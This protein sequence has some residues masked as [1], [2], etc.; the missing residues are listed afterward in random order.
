[1]IKHVYGNNII[2][3]LKYFKKFVEFFIRL[4]LSTFYNFKNYE[5]III[6]TAMYAPWIADNKFFKLF[7]KIQNLTLLDEARAYTLWYLSDSLKNIN[8]DILDIG[9]MKG[10]AGIVMAKA[11]NNMRSKTYFIDTFE[12]YAISS[13]NHIKEQTFVYK[14]LK[15]LKFNINYFKIKNYEIKKCRFPKKIKLK[16]KI[17]MC[18]LDINIYKDTLKAFIFVDK[19]LIKNGVIV[20]DDYGVHKVD[21]IIQA[22]NKIKKEFHTKYT[23]IYNYMG[24]CIMIKK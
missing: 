17:K 14:N 18:H 12:G 9:C 3:L 6:S 7:L 22:V 8:G 2:F 23:I 15:E 10:G 24:Q 19:H 4:F 5:K 13:G 16:K 21:E 11:N 20:F 1:M